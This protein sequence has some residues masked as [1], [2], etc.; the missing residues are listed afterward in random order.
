MLPAPGTTP[1]DSMLNAPPPSPAVATGQNPGTPLGALVPP[2]PSHQLPPEVLQGILQAGEQIAQM[3]DSFAQATPDLA[4]DWAAAKNAL[5][6]AMSKVLQAGAGPTSPTA[7]GPN[8][9]GG[10]LDRGGMPSAPSGG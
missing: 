6:T 10:G 9:P 3:I 8:F 4:M 2:I 7:T 1:G 5:M